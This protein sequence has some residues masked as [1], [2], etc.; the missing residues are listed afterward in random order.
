MA[1]SRE[2]KRVLT[3]TSSGSDS[4]PRLSVWFTVLSVWTVD[5]QLEK[6][7]PVCDVVE[8]CEELLFYGGQDSGL[9]WWG[10]DR[11]LWSELIVKIT[12]ILP[13]LNGGD[14][15]RPGLLSQ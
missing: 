10:Q 12:N 5:G 14:E 1:K 9:T 6:L 3:Q 8:V 11:S 2:R 4:E 7:T 13:S 15:R